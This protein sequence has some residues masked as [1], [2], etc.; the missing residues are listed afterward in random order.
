M[1]IDLENDLRRFLIDHSK[2]SFLGVCISTLGVLMGS[3]YHTST[4]S[5]KACGATSDYES[6]TFYILGW[7]R[8]WCV[9]YGLRRSSES[10]FLLSDVFQKVS[11]RYVQTRL[12]Y[13]G[14]A[15][16][17]RISEFGEVS[18]SDRT[19][20]ILPVAICLSQR[21]SHACLSI[22]LN[23]AKLRMAH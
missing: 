15:D 10:S 11:I 2:W 18:S 9:I 7:S 1:C 5:W 20:L 8:C 14:W 19:W 13:W 4:A 12:T 17:N 23:T 3:A 22:S 6:V 21:L 16:L